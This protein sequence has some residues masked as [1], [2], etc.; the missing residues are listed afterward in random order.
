MAICLGWAALPAA[1]QTGGQGALE[2]TVTDKSGSAI[3]NAT[4]TAI[5]QASGVPSTRQTSSA[6]LY[7]IT[8]LIPGVYTVKVTAPGFEVLS[9]QNIEVNGM[10]TTGFN[11]VL[12]VGAVALTV[13]VTAAPPQLQTTNATLGGVITNATYES[14]PNLMNGQQRD[15]TA[16]GI[17]AAGAQS[18]TRAPIMAGTGD[19]LAEVYLDG[20]PTTVSNMQADNRPVSNAVSIESVDQMQ[21]ISNGPT[22]EYQG[23]G[24]MSLT[25]KSGGDQYHG[26]IADFVRNTAFDSWGFTA[27]WGTQEAIVN[28][29]P[30]NVPAG[31][32]VEHQNELSASIGG[33]IKFTRHKGFFFVNWDQYHGRSGVEPALFTIPTTLMRQGTFSELGTGQYLYNPLTNACTGSTCTRQPF[34]GNIIPSANISAISQYQEKFLPPPTLSGISNNYLAGGLSGYDNHALDFKID[35]DLTARQRLSFVFTHG[36]RSSVGYGAVLP[37]PYPSSHSSILRPTNMILEHQF[38]LS[39]RMV[40]QL[41]Y[42]FTRFSGPVN[43][44]TEGVSPYRAGSDVGI[45]GLPPGQ[46]SDNFPTS[47][48]STTSAFPTVP[49]KWASINAYQTVP[50][51]FTVLDNLQWTKG[52]HNLTFGIQTQWLE[53]NNTGDLTQSG[54]YSQTFSGASTANYAGTSISTTT[55]GF[56]YADFLLGAVNSASIPLPYFSDIGGRYHPVSPYAQDDWKITPSL[57]LNIGLRWDY[58]PPYHEVLD[59]WSFLNPTAINPLTN[60]AGELE[61]AGNLGAAISCDCRTPVQTYWKNWGPRIGFAWSMNN[62]TVVRGGFSVAY[63]RAGGVGGR[64]DDATGTGQTGWG[65]NLILPAAVSKGVSAAPSYWLNQNTAYQN[66]GTANAN[67]GGPGFTIPAQTGASA[68]GLTLNTGNYV[69][70]SNAYVTPGGASGYVDPYLSGRGPE[71]EFFNFGIQRALTQ[72]LT[73]MASYAGS[74]S[75][76]VAGAGESGYWSGQIDPQHLALLGS[77]LATDNTTNII[78]AQATP[79]NIAI[80]VKADPSIS[81][82]AFYSAAGAISTKATIGRALQPYPQYSSPPGLAWDNIANISYN[83]IQVT[84]NERQWKGLSYTLNYTYSKDIGDDNT[85]RS[86]FPVPAGASS[87]GQALPGQNRA[88][89]DLTD[90]D[91]PQN[92]KIYG[93]YELPF[94]RGHWGGNNFFVRNVIGGWATSGIFTYLSGTPLLITGSGCNAPSQ[95]TCMPDLIPGMKNKI[96]ING[97]WGKGVYGNNVGAIPFL[98]W[99]A[100][101]APKTFPLPAGAN[102]AAVPTTMIGD[103]PR[104]ELA[105][106]GLRNPSHYDLDLSVRRSFNI[107]RERVKFIF[108]ADSTNVTNKVTFGGINAAWPFTPTT[109]T[110]EPANSTFGEAT[111]ANG[112]R[113]FQFAGK[114]TF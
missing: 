8:P 83:S 73:I 102:P 101:Q 110:V 95:G 46:A 54:P 34:T 67:F 29:V 77:V 97:S 65:S 72:N 6:G 66:A 3:P 39:P 91:T 17:L 71:F 79:A 47:N 52:K 42:G 27:P 13:T 1:S 96:R 61:Y 40:N 4:V 105:N 94:G 81:I 35:Y 69:N 5:D 84:L 87:N 100:F 68:A 53:D 21:V 30:T 9:Q 16:Y 43:V 93:L 33:P 44:P 109:P 12:S 80:A 2:G 114:I 98:N 108:Q 41:K 56:S 38:V 107:T 86:A 59:R 32:P 31:K 22:A 76:F 85:T 58:L 45:A 25:L 19:Y 90:I 60:T 10:T 92:L 50:N 14:L 111:T 28:G 7:E 55:T 78:N 48:F 11:P 57:T 64:A 63:S 75:H 89:R 37:I 23:A 15:P 49:Y 113:L 112:N 99:N 51:A 103:A 62:K 24:A 82:P 74:E 70:S 106:F 20:I 104:T 88:D 36:V 26:I 18:G